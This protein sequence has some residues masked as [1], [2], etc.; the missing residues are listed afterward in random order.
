MDVLPVFIRFLNWRLTDPHMMI[1]FFLT[2]IWHSET[3][4]I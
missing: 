3:H 2:E 1:S 4:K